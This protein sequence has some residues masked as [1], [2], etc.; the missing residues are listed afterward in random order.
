MPAPVRNDGSTQTW[1]ALE[2]LAWQGASA[3]RLHPRVPHCS[4]SSHPGSWLSPL[5][6]PRR[7]RAEKGR[8]GSQPHVHH[9]LTWTFG[10]ISPRWRQGHCRHCTNQRCGSCASTLTEIEAALGIEGSGSQLGT[11]LI[12]SKGCAEILGGTYGRPADTSSARG[13]PASGGEATVHR[14][15]TAHSPGIWKSQQRTLR[16]AA[17]HPIVLLHSTAR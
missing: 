11:C 16:E 17:T 14:T 2:P 13:S 15:A 8:S 4:P 12:P 6:C 7:L 1:Y 5:P 10:A 3:A 9:A